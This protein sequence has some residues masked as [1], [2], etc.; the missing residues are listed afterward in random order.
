M[1]L[2]ANA[3][4]TDHM[5]L[6][7]ERGIPV[8]GT[9]TDGDTVTVRIRETSVRDVVRGG[10][11]KVTLPAMQAGGPFEL[12]V[13]AGGDKLTFRDVLVGDVWLAGGQSNMEWRLADSLNAE[14]EAAAADFPRVRY[15]EVPRVAYDDGQEHAGAWAVCSPETALRF[16]A[17]GYHFARTLVG[18][19]DV[20][21][22]IVGCNWG[23]T[24]ASCWVPEEALANDPELRVYVDV[25]KE[26]IKD[27]NPETAKKEQADY[28]AAVDAWVRRQSEGLTGAELGDFPWPPPLN[29]LSFLR[30]SGLYGTMLSQAAPYAIKGFI[31]YQGESDADRTYLYDRLM[32]VLI[33][34]WRQDWGDAELP[35]LFVQL[36]GYADPYDPE[37]VNW[38]LLREA[39]Q[40]VTEQVP[41]TAMAVILD[42]GEENDIH[43]RDKRP[44]GERLGRIALKE[45]YGR[46][47]ACYGPFFKS[48]AVEGTK[49]IVSFSHAE[50]G[51]MSPSASGEVLGFEIAGTD[52]RFVKADAVI[53]G[54]TVAVSSAEVAAPAAVRYAWASWPA[55]TLKNGIGLPAAPFR[56]SI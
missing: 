4:F 6:Q 19:L 37:G 21:I 48:L 33:G 28:Q 45:V 23:G 51:L 41:N 9:G 26:K 2:Q 25:Y 40:K 55:A 39:Q 22:G 1:K 36:P 29:E 16:T 34:Q 27:L 17:V 56:T 18:E 13:E 5:V 53:A 35:F 8:W 20:P 46:D 42:C 14:Q 54:G 38:P 49:A 43:P 12:T 50:S 7:R 44:V 47:T 10:E 52:G 3:L 30:P 11:W 31:Y 24:S 15:Y 32:A